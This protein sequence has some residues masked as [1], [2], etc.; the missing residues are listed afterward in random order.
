[1]EIIGTKKK[2]LEKHSGQSE[3]GSWTKQDFILE[4]MEKFPR[5][6]CITNWKD[7]I[8]LQDFF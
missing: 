5:Q 7:K 4:T 2:K 8:A 1:M 6:A 3:K